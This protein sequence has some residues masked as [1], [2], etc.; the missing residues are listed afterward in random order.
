M[1]GEF[2]IFEDSVRVL[3]VTIALYDHA[4]FVYY[5]PNMALLP[6]NYRMDDETEG[7]G[8]TGLLQK[9]KK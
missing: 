5:R 3:W 2:N 8:E 4:V 7:E 1:I 6:V 9:Q